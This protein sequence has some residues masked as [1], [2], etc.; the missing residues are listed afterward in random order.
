MLF[1]TLSPCHLVSGTSLDIPLRLSSSPIIRPSPVRRT[2]PPQRAAL[3]IQAVPGALARV[4]KRPPRACPILARAS[5]QAVVDALLDDER[6]EIA[7]EARDWG[8]G[9]GDWEGEIGDH[10]LEICNTTA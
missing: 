7:V 2:H 4:D 5:R 9:V 10:Q 8:L 1:S 6:M 3:A